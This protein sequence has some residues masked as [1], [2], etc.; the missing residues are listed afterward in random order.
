M[1][2][3]LK[4]VSLPLKLGNPMCEIRT[5]DKQDLHTHGQSLNVRNIY[6]LVLTLLEASTH[7]ASLSV[8]LS[9]R[10]RDLLPASGLQ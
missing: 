8:V 9:N 2:V 6:C 10:E 5:S 4:S 3:V 7:L 1:Y